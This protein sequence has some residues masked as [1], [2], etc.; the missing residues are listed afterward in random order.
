MSDGSQQPAALEARHATA[1]GAAYAA[2]PHAGPGLLSRTYR[3][4][5]LG[6]VGLVSVVAFEAMGSATIMP[7]AATALDGLA[8]YGFLFGGPLAVSLL[9]MVLAGGWSDR[10]GPMRAVWLGT[11]CFVAGLLV[12]ALSPSVAWLLLGRLLTGMGSGM[13]GVALYAMVGHVYPAA[14][15]SRIFA[16]FAAAW[17]LPALLGPL[18]AG[19]IA[20]ALGW[21]PAIA[22]AAVLALPACLLLSRVPGS[23]RPA[24]AA[25]GSGV[26]RRRMLWALGASLGAV[27]LH[28]LGQ[29]RTGGAGAAHLS[30]GTMAC[31]AAAIGLLL[32]SAHRLLP[33]GSLTAR[34]GVPAAIAL[35]GLSQGAFFAA[36]A[37]LP[38][39]LHREKGASV[40]MAGLLLSAGAVTWSAGAFVRARMHARISVGAM[41]RGG[42]SLLAA[43]I[44]LSTLVLIPSAPAAVAMLGWV[45]AGA[46]MGLVSPT[47]S[48]TTLALAAPGAHGHAGASLRLSAALATTSTLAASGAAFALLLRFDA[49]GAYAISLGLAAVLAATGAALAGR[50]AGHG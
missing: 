39:L 18:L 49:T 5:T 16:A 9:G 32:V 28:V 7:A 45:L 37:F 4:A 8:V 35:S 25:G 50:V 29:A 38:L 11:A 31:G 30:T 17:M 12:A 46:G 34:R 23:P 42:F 47:L 40:G 13:I 24:P 19:L 33:A 15:H 44:L 27:V 3:A 36:E 48:V 20:D 41:L 10:H 1:G 26:F 21:R 43:G 22:T 2:S 6:V 14:L